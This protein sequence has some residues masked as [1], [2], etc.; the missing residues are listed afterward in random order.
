MS[1]VTADPKASEIPVSTTRLDRQMVA[2]DLWPRRHLER[3]AKASP[4]LP[5]AVFWPRSTEEVQA[6]VSRAREAGRGVVPFGA[7]SGVCNGI[8]PETRDDIVDVKRMNKVLELDEERALVRVQ[9][10]INGE[11]FERW[12]NARGWSLGHFPS[13]IYCST[14]GGWLAARSAGQLSSRYGKIEDLVFA[15]EAVDGTASV[16]RA[17]LDDPATGP[18]AIRLLVGSEGAFCIFTEVT[19]RVHRIASHR[20]LR[21]FVFND[22]SSGLEA[23]RG[24]FARGEPP[25]V[26]RLYDPLDTW[27]AGAPAQDAGPDHVQAGAISSAGLEDSGPNDDDEG[28]FG[29]VFSELEDLAIFKRPDGPRA[30]I[31]QLLAYPRF[32]NSGIDARSGPCKLI[33]GIEGDPEVVSRRAQR[34]RGHLTAGGGVD[35]GTGPGVK[36]LLKRHRVSYK[37]S[38]VFAAGAWVDTMEVCTGWDKVRDLYHEVRNA[39]RSRAMVMCHFSHAYLDGC[40]LYFTF[41]GGGRGPDEGLKRYDEVW[42]IALEVVRA[43]GATLSHHHGLG[44]SKAGAL[45]HPAGTLA[46]L[47]ELKGAL[48]PDKIM[49]RGVLGL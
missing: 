45:R 39:L 12:L 48:D 10:G 29:R 21:G 20:W 11:R 5:G 42:R 44:R 18:A 35:A 32:I 4:R 16:L 1:R 22:L 24:L 34:M 26:L 33:V 47:N 36:W 27:I 41:A 9:C 25:S 38:R 8:A 49:N 3:L 28:L 40:S 6:L 14:V 23:M 43:H 17:A 19:L 7:G 2:Q 46:L 37:M 31:G 30:A 15:L 13:S